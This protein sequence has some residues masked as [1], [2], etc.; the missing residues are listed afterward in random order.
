MLNIIFQTLAQLTAL[1]RLNLI[2][3]INVAG[4]WKLQNKVERHVRTT[5]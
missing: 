4:K 5:L 2:Q 1:L 3:I